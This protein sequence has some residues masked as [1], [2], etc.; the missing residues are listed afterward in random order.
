[1]WGE[2]CVDSW[3]ESLLVR[4]IF[5]HIKLARSVL[6]DGKPTLVKLQCLQAVS[7]FL[8]VPK[9]QLWASSQCRKAAMN[10]LFEDL[11]KSSMKVLLR[12]MDPKNNTT[13]GPGASSAKMRD[14]MQG[15]SSL[16]CGLPS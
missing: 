8:H 16:Q 7:A 3:A 12:E 6:S 4:S 11:L 2:D 9:R 15:L 10:G 14:V 1:M 5:L 13:R